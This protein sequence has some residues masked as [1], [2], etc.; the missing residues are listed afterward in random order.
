MRPIVC[1]IKVGTRY[2]PEYVNRLHAAV[3]RHMKRR[4]DFLCLTDDP[5]GLG[6]LHLPIG[7]DLPG[8]W[9]KLILFKPH[10]ALM[11]ARVIFLDLD[12]VILGNIDFLLAYEGDFAILRDFYRP[13]G[14]GSAIMSI[15]PAFGGRIWRDFKPEYCAAYPGDQNWIEEQAP[16]ADRW[17]DLN[18]GR[19]VSYKAD[20]QPW[21]DTASICCFHGVPKNDDLEADHPLR[22]IWEGER[23]VLSH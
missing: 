2:G 6:C 18:P 14:Y 3:E 16:H 17:Q 8:W 23:V 4:H 20:P 22:R 11:G 15:A 10:Q 19:I 5:R 1:C 12:T 13:N 9:A 21:P 7:T